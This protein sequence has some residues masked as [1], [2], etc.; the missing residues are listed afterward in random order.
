MR[1]RWRMPVSSGVLWAGA[2][3]LGPMLAGPAWGQ[4]IIAQSQPSYD[5]QGACPVSTRMADPPAPTTA[6]TPTTPQGPTAPQA[7]T[8]T[9]PTTPEAAAEAP[10]VPP[11]QEQNL[12]PE[13]GPGVGG[14]LFAQNMIGDQLFSARVRFVTVQGTTVTAV[15]KVIPLGGLGGFNIAEDESP[16]PQN[17]VYFNYNYFNEADAIPR[18]DVH[19]ETLGFEKTFF[20]GNASVGMRLP[21]FQEAGD[22][23]IHS[24]DIGDLTMI[25]KYALINDAPTGNVLSGGLVITAPTGPN[26]LELGDGTTVHST[27]LQP[28][29]GAIVNLDNFYI[30]GFSSIV[31][32]TDARDV[33]FLLNDVGVGYWL[34]RGGPDQFLAAVVPTVEAHVLTPLNHRDN[35]NDV[36][37][38]P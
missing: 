20:G 14:E 19:R 27:L 21:F 34:Y 1:F 5:F 36:I 8:P 37:E 9:T 22:G 16:R 31:V 35:V 15:T 17:R 29:A 26:E 13:Q 4:R 33:T 38:I 28:W 24:G 12:P 7:T 11:G 10:Q 6:Q 25:L 30:H 32:P 23:A 18:F 2:L 3:L